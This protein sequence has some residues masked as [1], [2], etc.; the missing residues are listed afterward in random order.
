M[1]KPPRRKRLTDADLRAEPDYQE[2]CALLSKQTETQRERFEDY[3]S[4]Q[5]EDSAERTDAMS[6]T[7][8]GV[9]ERILALKGEGRSYG[10]IAEILTRE[11]YTGQRGNPYG[12]SAVAKRYQRMTDREDA[13]PPDPCETARPASEHGEPDDETTVD[14]T[15]LTPAELR[16]LIREEIRSVMS[17]S[18]AKR[19]NIPPPTPRKQGEKGR[20]KFAGERV[21]LPGMRVDAVLWR[22]FEAERTRLGIGKSALMERILWSYFGE[23]LLS[24][25]SDEG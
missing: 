22:N 19:A 5:Q 14:L 25:Q 2:L 11:G 21:T 12:R 8:T 18:A 23:P 16:N 4:H 9:D 24:F 7:K 3:L 13:E 10:Q 1:S 17:A 6:A 15:A 20:R